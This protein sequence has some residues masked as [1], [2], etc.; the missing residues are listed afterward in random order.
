MDENLLLTHET[1]ENHD[2]IMDLD[3]I[4]DEEYLPPLEEIS[5]I[6]G[7][8]LEELERSYYASFYLSIRL[9]IQIDSILRID[10]DFKKREE[11][12]ND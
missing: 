10:Q 6:N 7:E 9:N 11:E 1:D 12:N 2:K 5:E 3:D 4:K 8:T